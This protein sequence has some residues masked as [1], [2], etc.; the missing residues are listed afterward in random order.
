MK[1][2]L[3][4]LSPTLLVGTSVCLLWGSYWMLPYQYQDLS[5][6]V[7][8]SNLYVNN[9]LMSIKA[10]DYWN[11]S[12][13][14]KPLMHTWY[15]GIVM[16]F[17]VVMAA[18]VIGCRF[19]FK[20]KTVYP[21]IVIVV[22]SFS[23]I[24][25]LWPGISFA[26]QFYYLPFR[27]FEFCAG[28]LV[29]IA[30][31]TGLGRKHIGSNKCICCVSL[32]AYVGLLAIAFMHAE[33]LQG[34]ITRLI[35]VAFSV[36][37]LGTYPY[38][39]MGISLFLS[40]KSLSYVGK[41]SFSIYIWHQIVF[42]FYRYSFSSSR[43]F[44]T[45]AILM[46][47]TL[48]LSVLSY[49]FIEKGVAR[50]LKTIHGRRNV[51][52]GVVSLSLINIGVA[53]YINSISGVIRDV[54]ELDTYVGRT[55]DR[56]HIAY[57]EA[58]YQMNKEFEK[59]D[60]LHWLVIGNSYGRDWVNVLREMKIEDRV[61]ISYIVDTRGKYSDYRDRI[62][63]ADLIFRTMGPEGSQSVIDDAQFLVNSFGISSE[64]IRIVSSK[65]FGYCCGQVY[66]HRHEKDYFSLTMEIDGTYYRDNECFKNQLGNRYI[67]LITPVTVKDHRVRVFTDDHKIIS[68][69]CIHLT[70][71][72]AKLYASLLRDRIL[73][74]LE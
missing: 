39:P 22:F 20:S 61:E 29:S 69:D 34:E 67:D 57:N 15:L 40:N 32:F 49:Q 43:D 55:T 35:V 26:K 21:W 19:L 44:E 17:Y 12:N 46:A 42:G 64:N 62:K 53:F 13:E 3:L 11:I 37:V 60:K 54:P 16:Q 7:I 56:M 2:R 9:V 63:A 5:Q 58:P 51:L 4:R 38:L 18:I 74:E 52:V 33:V 31:E 27:M 23:L 47:C 73:K 6:Y 1:D 14:F 28:M 50:Y 36:I 68:Q 48:V 24:L 59:K 8:A 71:N 25:Y 70:Q 66:S 10:W 72:G 41:A 45:F 30:L 65:R